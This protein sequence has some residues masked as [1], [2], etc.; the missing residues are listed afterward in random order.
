MTHTSGP[1]TSAIVTGS[2]IHSFSFGDL[3]LK[4]VIRKIT[5]STNMNEIFE[6]K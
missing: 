4:Q 2:N 1:Y 3:T 6:D 5:N